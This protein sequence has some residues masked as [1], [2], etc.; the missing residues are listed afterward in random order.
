MNRTIF[1]TFLLLS[2]FG[3]N[4]DSFA[5]AKTEEPTTKLAPEI[6]SQYTFAWSFQEG[7]NMKPRGGTT[8]GEGITLDKSI[9][10]QWRSI[11][12][13]GLSKFERDRR[14]I[15]AMSGGYRASFDFLE[16]LGL[17]ENHSPARPYQS[18]GTEYVYVV[19]D[20]NN[21]ISLQHVLVMYFE[22]N[23]DQPLGPMV[24]KHWRQDWHYEDMKIHTY[25]G[26]NTWKEKTLKDR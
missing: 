11:Q 19:E 4:M 6:K 13:T 26:F 24:M 21:F 10:R 16:T 25:Q 22:S 1:Y 23:N 12:E 15:L 2:F 5:T 9:N 14:A 7:S 18:W 17:T 3:L 20:K 8:T